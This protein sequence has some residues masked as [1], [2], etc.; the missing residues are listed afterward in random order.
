MKL[1]KNIALASTIALLAA[2]AAQAEPFRMIVTDLEPPL[3]PNSIIDFAVAGGYFTAEGVDLELV[4]VEQT[5]SALAAI[6]AGEG[7]MANI[8]VDSLLQLVANGA[9]DLRAVLTPNKALPYQ[10]IGKDSIATLADMEGHS[11]GVGRVGS[12]DYS[13]SLNV[14][15]TGGVDTDK[16]EIVA[17][18]QPAVRAQALSAGQ[19]DATTVSLGIWLSLPEK[20]G[21]HIITN[22]DDFYAAAPVVNK[23]NIVTLATLQNRQAEVDGIT[24][25]VIRA[26][27]DVAENSQ[28]WVDFMTTARP[29]VSAETLDALA[30]AF[31][32]SWSVN[33]GLSADELN[34]TAEWA[35][36]GEEFVGV[37]PVTLN[38]WV[39]FGPI[40]RALESLGTSDISDAVTR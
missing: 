25:A 31:T 19:V 14:L 13:L 29:D 38:E 1:T 35:Y 23:V 18:G 11:F 12:L 2:G 15:S 27:R 39:D 7:E 28:L 26:S 20:D 8:S 40:D 21:L 10:I 36:K 6:Q 37:R 33:G 30:A 32:Q 16:V 9:D 3:V 34:F 17:L 22:V 5:P 4:R 24:R